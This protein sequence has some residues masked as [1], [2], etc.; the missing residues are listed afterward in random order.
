MMTR[1]AHLIRATTHNEY[2]VART[3]SMKDYD[4]SL[5]GYR[6]RQWSKLL[7]TRNSK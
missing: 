1:K 5:T 3:R 2:C 6:P 4:A 7:L